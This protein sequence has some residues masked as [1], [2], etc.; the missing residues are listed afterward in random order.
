MLNLEIL[1]KGVTEQNQQAGKNF[2]N[3]LQEASKQ[4]VQFTEFLK[5]LGVMNPKDLRSLAAKAYGVFE[6]L[7]LPRDLRVVTSKYIPLAFAEAQKLVIMDDSDNVIRLATSKPDNVEVLTNLKKKLNRDMEIYYGFE[8]EV[9][10]SLTDA[11]EDMTAQYETL[12]G[13]A[14]KD[15]TSIESL[16]NSSRLLDIILINAL[17]YK[18][19]DIHIEPHEGR[20]I[21]RFRVDGD[22]KDIVELPLELSEIITTRIK[23]LADLRID[24][25][26]KPQD[27]RFKLILPNEKE[28]TTRVSILP[29]Y[30]GEKVVM[31]ILESNK[32]KIQLEDLG[33]SKENQAKIYDNVEKS[34]GMLLVTGPT[35]SGKTTTLYTVLKLLNQEDVNLMT[36]ED[37][38]E[39]RLDRVNQIQVNEAA[40]LT[41]AGG[42][43][44]ILRQDP[45]IVMVGEI[46]DEETANIAVNA[47]L[48]GHLVLATLHTNSAIDTLPRLIEMGV[49]PYLVASTVN[50]VVAQRLV[51]KLCDECKTSVTYNKEY[52]SRFITE[53]SDFSEELEK[54]AQVLLTENATIC[55]AA[56]CDKCNKTGYSG[57]L[58]IAEVLD[59]ND[60]IKKM[61][62]EKKS[63]VEIYDAARADNFTVLLEDG[64]AKVADGRVSLDEVV[65][66]LKE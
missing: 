7:D 22:L 23:V 32:Q 14:L 48:T 44:S 12:K 26:Q 28:I 61:I 21:V 50:V 15:I 54:Y 47:S 3:Y 5:G 34:H 53:K 52:L 66:V 36:V 65:R 19:S 40:G 35:G 24:E 29:V 4:K 27:G 13:S 39:Y 51:R 9:L 46:R 10:K 16:K 45:D 63:P 25:H 58:A 20:L 64:L 59:V 43:R 41:F 6:A 57:R 55:E 62:Y 30:K 17:D 56:G 31:R 8:E 1:Q 37:P 18:S 33:Y 2:D 38:I 11:K 42:L 60:A 49:E